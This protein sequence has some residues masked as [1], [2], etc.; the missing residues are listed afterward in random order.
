M[1]VPYLFFAVDSVIRDGSAQ[2]GD[3]SR[4]PVREVST[5]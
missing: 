1:H 3:R 2:R 4:S 5:E